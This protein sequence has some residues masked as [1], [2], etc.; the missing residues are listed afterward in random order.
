M[1]KTQYALEIGPHIL[2][3]FSNLL[4]VPDP[5]PKH[6]VLALPHFIADALE[7]WGLISF[8]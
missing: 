8:G 6:D 3:L 2:D 7:N 1:A 4:A 5:L